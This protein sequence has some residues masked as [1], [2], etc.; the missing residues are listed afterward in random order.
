MSG[1][2]EAS[3]GA[4]P[5]E[6]EDQ[7]GLIP[8]WIATRHDLNR[9][10]QQNIATAAV[11]LRGRSWTISDLSQAWLKDL[12]RRM[13][14]TVWVW[15]GSYRRTD[16]NLGIAWFEIPAAVKQLIQDLG[17]QSAS[18][19]WSADEIAVRF[20]HQLVCIHPFP[21]G[22]GRHARLSADAL[23]EMLGAGRFE[24]GAGSRLLDAGRAREEYL[25][26]LRHADRGDFAALLRF[27]RSRPAR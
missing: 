11:W 8:T 10:E 9:A 15:A 24:W 1:I 14:G 2:F 19:D 3:P 16:T 21:N 23:V 4:T 12:H 20:H 27:A 22:N 13:F 17:T 7:E 18:R 26:A 5:L 25:D 6:P